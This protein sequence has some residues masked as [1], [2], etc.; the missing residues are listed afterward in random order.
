MDNI[1][2]F[3]ASFFVLIVVCFEGGYEN[4]LVSA[5]YSTYLSFSRLDKG[6]IATKKIS[7]E[8]NYYEIY[9]YYNNVK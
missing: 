1:L 6:L 5:N 4:Y 3:C 7:I 8:S 2:K 9:N